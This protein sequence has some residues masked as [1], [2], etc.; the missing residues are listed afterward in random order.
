M[1]KLLVTG[2][3][4]FLGWNICSVAKTQWN[5]TGIFHAHDIPIDGISKLQCDMCDASALEEVFESVRPDAV[6]H[7]AAIADP[8]KCQLHPTVSM[9]V[10]VEASENIA[11]LCKKFGAQCAF[12]STDLVFNGE[13]PPYSEQNTVCPVSVYGEHKVEAENRMQSI[14]NDML[15]CRM[16]LMFGNHPGPAKSFIQPWIENLRHGKALSLFVDEFR[17]P[18]SGEDAARGILLFLT[19]HTGIIHLGG[20]VRISRFDFGMLLAN[21]LGISSPQIKPSLQKDIQTAAGRPKDVSL[22]SSKAFSLGFCPDGPEE[23]LLNLWGN[24]L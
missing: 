8:N 10:N 6:I 5:V 13:K 17:T 18:V 11:R 22:D 4:G 23:A 7:A 1:Q 15:I 9:R 24:R 2:A 16:P 14:N 21:R 3:S 20:K 12:T 19:T